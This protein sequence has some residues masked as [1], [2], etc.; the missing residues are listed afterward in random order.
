MLDPASCLHSLLPPPD[1][2]L[3]PQGLDLLKLFQK[4]ILVPSATVPSSNML[5]TLSLPDREQ[6]KNSQYRR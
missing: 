3:L 6:V 4:S 2:S 1:P 5:L